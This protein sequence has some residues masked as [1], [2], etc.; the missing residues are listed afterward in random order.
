MIACIARWATR[1]FDYFVDQGIPG[2]KP[3]PIVGNLWGIWR[4]VGSSNETS[5]TMERT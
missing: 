2:P 3:V 1:N 5:I 4:R